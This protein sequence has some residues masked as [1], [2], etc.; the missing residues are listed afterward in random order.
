MGGRRLR[1]LLVAGVVVSSVLV[2]VAV[3]WRRADVAWRE[4]TQRG[5]SIEARLAAG[6]A[7]R[8]VLW[9]EPTPGEAWTH[10]ERA[11]AALDAVGDVHAR[12]LDYRKAQDL[13]EAARAIEL[14][15]TL[16]EDGQR[17]L[18]ALGDGARCGS[19]RYGVTWSAGFDHA[20][21]NLLTTR[22]LA[23]LAVIESRRR[24]RRGDGVGAARALLDAMQLGGDLMRAPVAI[25]EMIGFAVLA[26]ASKQALIDHGVLDDLSDEGLATLAT[27]MAA[28]DEAIPMVGVSSLGEIAL[29]VRHVEKDN[30]ANPLGGDGLSVLRA[31]RFGFSL[32]LL[33]A[34]HT[35]EAEARAERF[36]SLANAGWTVRKQA[37]EEAMNQVSESLNP[38]TRASGGLLSLHVNRMEAVAWLRLARMAVTFRRDGVV[39][40][41]ADPFGDQLHWK[42]EGDRLRAWSVGRGPFGAMSGRRLQIETERLRPTAPR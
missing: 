24:A 10:Y 6:G 20:L 12:W 4:M 27:G 7:E 37:M 9:G 42:L 41:L 15:D 39:R 23:N 29:F 3:H 35:R 38:V 5:R 33:C 40:A 8:P 30:G 13:G 26:V 34:D 11:L 25:D 18:D 16:A 19:A 2:G 17:S 22:H 21:H 14:G 36:L 28:L 1:I 32:R 31:W